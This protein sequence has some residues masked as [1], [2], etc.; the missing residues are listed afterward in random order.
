MT[1]MANQPRDKRKTAKRRRRF[2]LLAVTISFLAGAVAL[3][4]HRTGLP[5]VEER[6][7]AIEAAR[8]IPDSENAAIIYSRLLENPDA[9]WPDGGL[10]FIDADS[11]MLTRSQPW[12]ERDYPE[13]ADWIKERQ[14]L[15]DELLV[16]STL[17]KCH[18]PINIEPSRPGL[19]RRLRTMR[20]WQRLLKRAANNDVAEDRIDD[21][22]AKWRCLIQVGGH[23]QQ[24][25]SLIEFVEGSSFESVGANQASAYVMEGDPDEHQLHRI[26]SLPVE[27]R[28]NWD[29]FLGRIAP[30]EELG[31]KEYKRS[32]GLVDRLKYEFGIGPIGSAKG[33]IYPI[34]R[35]IYSKALASKRGLHILVAL[36]RYQKQ[37]RRWPIDLSEIQP[38]VSAEILVDPINDGD[39]VYRLTN[40]GFTLYSKGENKVDEGGQYKSQSKEGPDDRRIWPPGGRKTQSEGAKNE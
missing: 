23:L 9:H 6:L 21:A 25:W 5:S 36:K 4:W 1:E 3:I 35:E 14:W 16:A 13:L 17:E 22:I 39:F 24:Q 19:I 37:Y 10:A 27:T 32:L 29:T 40:D 30:V 12:L 15:I 26:A 7:A 31:E 33:R 28:D 20:R 38:S 18:F 8:A 34:M 2:T 11:D